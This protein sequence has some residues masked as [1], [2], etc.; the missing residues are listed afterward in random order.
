MC[1]CVCVCVCVAVAQRPLWA[2][3]PRALTSVAR[4]LVYSQVLT[5]VTGDGQYTL[6]NANYSGPDPHE[7]SGVGAGLLW[8]SQRMEDGTPNTN[9]TH[10]ADGESD[11]QGYTG[12]Y[13]PF[14]SN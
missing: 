1:V 9:R 12:T 5:P 14:A 11:Y 8:S 13:H 2:C 6:P 4:V 3:L 7:F 10:G